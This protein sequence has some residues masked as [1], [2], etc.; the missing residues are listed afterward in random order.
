MKLTEDVQKK[1]SQYLFMILFWVC[2]ITAFVS[3]DMTVWLMEVLP[4]YLGFLA[5]F[6]LLD[7]G[8]K[9]SLLLH[10]VFFVQ[11]IVLTIGGIY[12]YAKVPF[13]NPTDWLGETLDWNRNNYDRLGH[14]MQGVTP[15][16][17]TKEL[18]VKRKMVKR[19]TMQVFLCI[20]V[21]LAVSAIY[22]LF[23]YLTVLISSDFAQDFVAS[24]GDPYDTQKDMLFA[25]LGA[26]F[27]A[28]AFVNCRYQEEEEMNME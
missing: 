3:V 18:L 19:S 27:A 14:F 17:A 22:E 11:I 23:E 13:F 25:L 28:C 10:I 16:L 7:K 9:F 21:S 1:R 8:V 15:Y 2:T 4:A 20:S 6:I 5:I 24:Q 26:I 12:T